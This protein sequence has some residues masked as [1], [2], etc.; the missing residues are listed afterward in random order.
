MLGQRFRT[1]AKCWHTFFFLHM[2][3]ALAIL[4]R[5]APSV[6]PSDSDGGATELNMAAGTVV[7]LPPPFP[8]NCCTGEG[9]DKLTI[10]DMR[11]LEGVVIDD[12]RL[13][14]GERA[15]GC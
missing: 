4:R 9:V 13:P 3:Q 12:L 11:G 5:F 14:C 7:P 1:C 10:F 15:S 6:P 2:S 8:K